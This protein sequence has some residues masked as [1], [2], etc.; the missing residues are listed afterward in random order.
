MHYIYLQNSFKLL[1]LLARQCLVLYIH[2]MSSKSYMSG[3]FSTHFRGCSFQLS[4]QLLTRQL[5]LPSVLLLEQ[6]PDSG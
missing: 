3:F 1:V 2:S 4:T 6:L 5:H